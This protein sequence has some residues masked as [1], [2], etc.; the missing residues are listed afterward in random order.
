LQPGELIRD[1]NVP[2]GA[3]SRRARYL[4]IRDRASYEFAL[5]STAAALEIEDGVIRQVRLAAGGVGTR[6]WRLQASE[7]ALIGKAPADRQ[8]FEAAAQLALEGARP[9]SGNHYKIELLP[10]TI[11]RALEMAVDAA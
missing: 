7:D 5:V 9:L 8:A 10:R 6:P 4:K 3:H 2:G 1:V 11:V